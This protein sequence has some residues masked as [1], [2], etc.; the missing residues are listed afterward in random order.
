[1]QFV[2]VKIGNRDSMKRVSIAIEQLLLGLLGFRKSGM[3]LLWANILKSESEV[4]QSCLTL[5][6]PMDCSLPGSSVHGIF[7]AILLEWIAISF[8]RGYSQPRYQTRVSC[9]VDR[10]FTVWATREINRILKRSL[11]VDFNTLCSLRVLCFSQ[12][13][14]ESQQLWT[15]KGVEFFVTIMV[16][17][18]SLNPQI[19]EC[20]LNW[21]KSLCRCN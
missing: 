5:C 9:I 11:K 15:N 7:Q 20:F 13:W 3:G 6:D 17:S 18:E 10:C 19:C 4:A 21:D 14:W 8:S 1:M 12:P 16:A 2:L